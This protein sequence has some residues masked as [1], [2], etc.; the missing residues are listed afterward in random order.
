MRIDKSLIFVLGYAVIYMNQMTTIRNQVSSPISSL[1]LLV[2]MGFL[3]AT[4]SYAVLSPES[5]QAAITPSSDCS[6]YNTERGFYGD[7]YNLS[8]ADPGM[9]KLLSSD[10]KMNKGFNTIIPSPVS[11][12]NPWYT[13]QYLSFG[14]VDSNILFSN[15]FPINEGR[16]GD[17]S[18]FAVHW[19]AAMLA[20]QDGFYGFTLAAD[21]D[22]WLI[23]DGTTI[24]DMGN[25]RMTLQ[26]RQ[27]Q[28]NLGAGYHVFDLYYADRAPDG[29]AILFD[30]NTQLE[31]HPLP[32]WCSLNDF[33]N[34]RSSTA[35]TS[36]RLPGQQAGSNPSGRVL[37]AEAPKP[38]TYTP[39]V[40]L[41]RPAG[42][43]DIYAIYAN[44]Y[45]HYISGPTAFARYG[46][47]FR[48]VKTVP[49]ST[50]N[51]YPDARLLRSPE[52]ATVYYLYPRS[53]RQ[54]LK[55]DLPSPTVFVSYADN[56]WGDIVVVDE[57]DIRAY[58]NATLIRSP[59]TKNIYYLKDGMRR[60]IDSTD[61]IYKLGRN[62]SDLVEVSQ[63]HLESYR[64]GNPM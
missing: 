2:S 63:L 10:P 61:T 12:Q 54:W 36:T 20:P 7:Y 17:P 45:R 32:S 38:I 64:E 22:A 19:R 18:N 39:A 43:S 4:L 15:F 59:S 51:Q 46:H 53:A 44:G 13:N 56:F 8:S 3:V 31:F 21:D 9:N 1:T 35:T 58:P 49:W 23:V 62:P 26:P 55:L 34:G 47:N 33:M 27:G 52:N 40:A 37:G 25:N 11:G 16:T 24:M 60:R 6:S 50:L 57:L 28:M 14:R 30:I 42:T 5:V 48:N 41:Y 29:A